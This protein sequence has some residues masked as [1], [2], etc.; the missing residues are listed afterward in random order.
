MSESTQIHGDPVELAALYAAGALGPQQAAQLEALA[1]EARE[2]WATELRSFLTVEEALM[3][4]VVPVPVDGRVRAALLRRVSEHA[5][6]TDTSRVS[7]GT[8]PA[9]DR[10]DPLHPDPQVWRR[11]QPD[12]PNQAHSIIRNA[13]GGQWEDTGIEGIRIR[14]LS[15]DPARNQMSML[16]RMAAGTGYPAHVH[17]GPEECLVLEGDLRTGDHVLRAGDYQRMTPGSRHG[18]QS[19]EHGCLLFIVSS[20]TDELDE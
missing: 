16:V 2:P 5:A 15:A 14:R 3:D 9:E 8:G 12:D 19:T 7:A 11:W 1:E 4:A 13:A 10:H 20:L 17:N 18:Y 6:A